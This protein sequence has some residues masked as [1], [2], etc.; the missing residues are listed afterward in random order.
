MPEY[1][2]AA[3]IAHTALSFLDGLRVAEDGRFMGYRHSQST[4]RPILYA[5]LAA[6][7]ARHLLGAADA[8]SQEEARSI[9]GF[10]AEDGLFKDPAIACKEAETEDWWGWT[11]LTLHALMTLGLY[12]LVAPKPIRFLDQY[13]DKDAFAAYLK[14]REWGDR[15]AWTSNELQNLGVMLQYARDFQADTRAGEL[16]DMLLDEIALRQRPENGLFGAT[17]D[18]PM[19]H[20]NGVQAG[21]HFWLLALYDGRTVADPDRILDNV[22]KTQNQWGGFGVQE[23]SSACEDIDSIDPLLRFTRLTGHRRD[24]V[25]AALT[26]A[27]P[28]VLKN[29]NPGGGW[30]FRRGEALTVVHPEMSSLADQGNAFYTWFRLLGLA[31][32]LNGLDQ[33][34]PGLDYPWNF[35]RAP[36]HQFL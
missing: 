9:T 18:T 16:M 5:T 14:S 20:S 27:L 34:P 13:R 32:L 36:G 1:T 24:D 6:L 35:G 33:V 23:N 30:V 28:A 2:S 25:Q 26:R 10:Q 21:Y 12:G 17:F 29:R 11:H 31:Y 4:T 15:A 3:E 7:L 19:K 8:G 22:L